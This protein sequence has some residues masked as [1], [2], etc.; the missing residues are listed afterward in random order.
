MDESTITLLSATDDNDDGDTIDN[1]VI[2]DKYAFDGKSTSMVVP[3]E[4]IDGVIPL[5]F[6]LTFSM[7][8]SRGSKEEQAVK[9]TILCESDYTSEFFCLYF[10]NKI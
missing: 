4:K 1:S 3:P 2:T 10:S 5:K 8:H 7:K 9:Q 6:T